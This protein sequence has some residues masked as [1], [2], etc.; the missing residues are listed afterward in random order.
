MERFRQDQGR[1]EG[2][3]SDGS[4]AGSAPHTVGAQR[5]SA[6]SPPSLGRSYSWTLSRIFTVLCLT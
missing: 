3:V 5:V 4:G 1:G 6:L 2:G